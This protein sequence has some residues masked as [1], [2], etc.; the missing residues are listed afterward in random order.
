[1][2]EIERSRSAFEARSLIYDPA[3]IAPAGVF[4]SLDAEGLLSVDRGYVRP[5]DEARV[6]VDPKGDA[7]D[8]GE[9]SEEPKTNGVVQPAVITV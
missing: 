6:V 5:G 7:P 8:D 2:A 4:I 3:E 1:L 9:T